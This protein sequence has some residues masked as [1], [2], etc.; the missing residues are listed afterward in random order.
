MQS[1]AVVGSK[2][3]LRD[4]VLDDQE[5][6][7]ILGEDQP[8]ERPAVVGQALRLGLILRRQAST[9][10][11]VGY[12]R[13]DFQTLQTAFEAFWKEQVLKRVDELVTTCF[14]TTSGARSTLREGK[15]TGRRSEAPV[16]L[17]H[18]VGN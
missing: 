15:D 9:A 13:R 18:G 17:R 3:I 2:I 4:F 5:A 10:V 6:A 7:G 8:D 12:V 16:E 11:N 14:D 1:V